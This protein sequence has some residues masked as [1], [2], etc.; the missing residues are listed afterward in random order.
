MLTE[1]DVDDTNMYIETS[2][3]KFVCQWYVKIFSS[4]T[5]TKFSQYSTKLDP[6]NSSSRLGSKKM[7]L[8]VVSR[9][10]SH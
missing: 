8:Q 2:P 4:H 9:V 3:R 5:A 1:K 6:Y 7:G 10:G